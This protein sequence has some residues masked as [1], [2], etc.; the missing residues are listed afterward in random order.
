MP[1]ILKN[2]SGFT[3]ARAWAALDIAEIEGASVRV[4]WTNEPY[5]WHANDGVEAFMVLEGRVTM[6]YRA[7]GVE[8]VAEL[9]QHDVFVAMQGD[10]HIAH[11]HGEARVLV[12]ERKGSV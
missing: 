3:S 6:R 4:H 9:E 5:K 11:P 10:E 2:I 1:R 12:I 8:H 7:D